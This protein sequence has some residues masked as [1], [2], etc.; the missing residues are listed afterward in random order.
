MG[1]RSGLYISF[2]DVLAALSTLEQL[3][4]PQYRSLSSLCQNAVHR[5]GSGNVLGAVIAQRERIEV[6]NRRLRLG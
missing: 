5:S 6:G 3:D 1:R 2:A 4:T